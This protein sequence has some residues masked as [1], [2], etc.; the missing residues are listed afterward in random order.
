MKNFVKSLDL[1]RNHT[2][3]KININLRYKHIIGQNQLYQYIT[4]IK[5]APEIMVSPS[6]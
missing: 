6:K 5:G 4:P 2:C 3:K 1:S